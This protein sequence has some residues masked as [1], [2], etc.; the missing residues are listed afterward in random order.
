LSLLLRLL[1]VVVASALESFVAAQA[2]RGEDPEKVAL[3]LNHK[4]VDRGATEL[5]KNSV[6]PATTVPV[7]V[8][9]GSRFPRLCSLGGAHAIEAGRTDTVH[10]LRCCLKS[11]CCCC[12]VIMV[13]SDNADRAIAI[14]TTNRAMRVRVRVRVRVRMQTKDCIELNWNQCQHQRQC[15]CQRQRHYKRL[16]TQSWL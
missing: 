8:E 11:N 5:P 15:Q 10:R 1:F 6:F 7:V 2:D 12:L 14:A 3:V 9:I 13:E 16:P 4:E